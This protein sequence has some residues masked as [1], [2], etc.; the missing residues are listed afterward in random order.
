MFRFRDLVHTKD[1]A[2]VPANLRAAETTASPP[3]APRAPRG[4]RVDKY[5]GGRRKLRS[6]EAST[7]EIIKWMASHGN[8]FS[9]HKDGPEFALALG[10]ARNTLAKIQTRMARE[11][12]I[13]RKIGGYVLKPVKTNLDPGHE[14]NGPVY[15]T[16]AHKPAQSWH[17]FEE[18]RA[19]LLRYMRANGSLDTADKMK[20]ASKHMGLRNHTSL[21]SHLNKMIQMGEVE[22]L[23]QGYGLKRRP[24][25]EPPSLPT[26]HKSFYVAEKE[27]HG[28]HEPQVEQKEAAPTPGVEK[29]VETTSVETKPAEDKPEYLRVDY[30]IWEY[31]KSHIDLPKEVLQGLVSFSKWLQERM[32]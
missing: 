21:Y 23:K 24:S 4:P 12:L 9:S 20:T 14:K 29:P 18:V 31:V 15:T 27:L 2:G 26:G 10:K 19:M 8:Q 13:N 17:T 7:H 6:Y 28:L 1:E 5:T 32:K 11:G 3:R 16:L 30:L 25:V 22:K